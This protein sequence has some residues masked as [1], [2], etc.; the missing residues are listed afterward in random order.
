MEQ[1]P[2]HSSPEPQRLQLQ[3][4]D[5]IGMCQGNAA[6][7][8]THLKA[9]QPAQCL[10]QHPARALGPCTCPGTLRAPWDPALGLPAAGWPCV[11]LREK[12]EVAF[13]SATGWS[14]QKIKLAS[15]FAWTH[16]RNYNVTVFSRTG[17]LNVP[18]GFGSLH[19][20]VSNM[21]F[22]L[23]MP[24]NQLQQLWIKLYL[25][26][27]ANDKSCW[28]CFGFSSFFFL[29]LKM[30]RKMM[31]LEM[32]GFMW[33]RRDACNFSARVKLCYWEAL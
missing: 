17:F 5:S 27:L 14:L 1:L 31:W 25:A 11:T 9:A 26:W 28:G 29:L 3:G 30:K 22:I 33:S 15:L 19:R 2:H 13:Q 21:L 16:G 7:P 32:S 6:K 4:C 10:L 18:S 24:F 20:A 12:N 23:Y 8:I